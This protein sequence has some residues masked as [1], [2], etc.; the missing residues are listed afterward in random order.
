MST[1]GETSISKNN[2]K[3][4]S[5]APGQSIEQFDGK[6]YAVWALRMKNILRERKLLKYIDART[7]IT[8]YDAEEDQQALSEIQFAL[9]NTQLRLTMSSETAHNAWERLKTKHQNTSESNI[10]FLRNQ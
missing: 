5:V 6:D 9:S 2:A 10:I 4:V 8:D 3:K 1:P 7:N